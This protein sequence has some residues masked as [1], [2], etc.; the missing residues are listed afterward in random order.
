VLLRKELFQKFIKYSF[1]GFISTCIYFLSVFIFVERFHFEPVFGS[2]IAFIIMTIVSFFMNV[3][4][5]FGS[6]VTY[7]KLLRFLIVS[8]VGFTINFLLMFLIVQILSYHYLVGEFV[9]ILVIPLVNFLL[10][11]YWTF[12]SQVS[13]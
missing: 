3:H 13:K 4:Y 6:D 11:N 2:A 8:T 12:Q 7:Q 1:V 9:T 5:T 10:N